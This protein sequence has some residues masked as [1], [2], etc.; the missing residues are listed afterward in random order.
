MEK[1]ERQSATLPTLL[2]LFCAL[3]LFYPEES[4]AHDVHYSISQGNAY[5]VDIYYADGTKFAFE[6][7]EIYRPDNE[8]TAYQVGRTNEIG[9]I[10]F[11]PDRAGRWRL[12]AFSDD[13]HGITV[14]ID[15]KEGLT[16]SEKKVDFFE[17]FAR[18]IF[19]VGIILII[20][21]II[22]IFVRRKKD[23]KSN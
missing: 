14:D 5:I 12:K 6:S 9:R 20:F 7:Y 18:P 4:L 21:A 1:R 19:G 17:R 10:A 16:I 2:V 22:N 15:V 13:G 23:E 8:K 3:I 11:V